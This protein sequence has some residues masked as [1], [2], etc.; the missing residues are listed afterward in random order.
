MESALRFFFRGQIVE[1]RGPSIRTTVLEWLRDWPGARGTKEGCAEGDCGA[2]TVVVGELDG[3]GRL[4]LR[5]VNACIRLLPSLHGKALFTVE[6]LETLAGGAA[7]PVQ[8]ALVE[9]HGSQCGFCT[10]GFAMS[11][12]A[13]YEAAGQSV[14]RRAELADALAGN[15][16]RCTGYRPILDAGEAMF[17]AA[18][19]KLA[20]APVEAALKQIA[21]G[22]GLVYEAFDAAHGDSRPARFCAPRSVAELSA[23]RLAQPQACLLAGGTDLVLSVTKQL[24]ELGDIHFLGDVAE[25]QRIESTSEGL[26]I[27]AA[28]PLED[29]WAALVAQR[30][31]LAR[32]A[33]RFAGPPVRHAGTLVGNLANGSPIGDAAPMLMAAGAVLVLVRGE[34]RR[35][36]ALDGFYLGYRSNALAAGEWIAAVR[37]PAPRPG[38]VLRAW[39]IAKRHDSDISAVAAGLAIELDDSGRVR[40]ARLAFGGLAATVRRAPQAEAALIGAVWDEA[41]LSAAQAA[42]AQDFAPIDDLRASA[43]YRRQVAAALLQRFWLA[44]RRHQPFEEDA[45]EVWSAR[46]VGE[47]A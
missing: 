21:Q 39:K 44:T 37:V 3:A 6:D 35:E 5:P 16:C 18:P 11:L 23:L 13:A 1:V 19:V 20:R 28:V 14:P 10:P 32:Y 30:P 27:G 47:R 42:L 17:A 4:K 24:R 7:H 33:K 40:A 41:T 31:A 8:A 45:L 36:V 26:L 29:A 34:A 22:P 12:F 46:P 25:L 38:E 43:E 9:H 2:C 15:L